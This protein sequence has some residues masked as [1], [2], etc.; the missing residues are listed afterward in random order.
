MTVTS[1]P[2]AAFRFAAESSGAVKEIKNV[3][4]N[5]GGVDKTARSLGSTLAKVGAMVSVSAFTAWVQ[6]SANA[7]DALGKTADRLNMAADSLSAY[8][9][10][11]RQ[12]GASTEVMNRALED[13]QKRLGEAING[14]GDAAK[15]I[16]RLGLSVSDLAKLSPDELFRV[17]AK[18]IGNL[19][20]RSEQAA[21]AQKL[22]GQSA[23]SLLP[24]LVDGG[25]ALDEAAKFS[26]KFGLALSRVEIRKI[27]QAND[28]LDRLKEV[29]DSAARRIA[30]GL[31]PAV[32]YFADQILGAT[33]DTRELQATV[34]KLSAVAI[35]AFEVMANGARSLEAAFFGIAAGGARVAQAL[36]FGSVS[37]A[38]AASVDENLR[39]ADEALQKIK[40]IEEIQQKVAD[41]LAGAQSRAS[42]SVDSGVV[43][44]IGTES[45]TGFSIAS[46]DLSVVLAALNEE[47]SLLKEAIG[48]QIAARTEGY[49]RSIQIEGEFNSR[50]LASAA[51]AE[52]QITAARQGTFDAAIG[53]LQ[54][55]ASKSKTA[56]KALVLI[57]R[58]RAIAEAIQNT[59][60]GVTNQLKGDPYSAIPRAIAVGMFGAAQVALIAAT[61]YSEMQTINSSGGAPLGSTYNPIAT[62]D[63]SSPLPS[64]DSAQGRGI[65]E[66]HVHGNIMSGRETADWLIDTFK[67]A[68]N[69]RDVVVIRSGSRQAQEL[70]SR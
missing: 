23:K 58:G 60:V 2:I 48:A 52:E 53:L 7:A 20:S 54:S 68:V 13:A 24:L 39:K 50:R 33:G 22:F 16:D 55:Y 14:S 12:T 18:E 45:L 8:Q 51:E 27:E 9:L 42:T 4:R 34:E 64:S 1:I 69:E 37:E 59:A 19:S 28:A 3:D 70:A 35:T 61:A 10:A 5:L 36:T 67:E 44:D 17:Y 32:E 31:S 25:T 15:I 30:V 40:S 65:V 6:S 62:T 66:F 63:H 29:S 57:N 26:E 11:A 41:V 43:G 49:E 56:A 46:P 38:F 47:T 21:V